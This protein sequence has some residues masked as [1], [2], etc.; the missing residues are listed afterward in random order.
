M[1]QRFLRNSVWIDPLE[2]IYRGDI[3]IQNGCVDRLEI[4]E[5]LNPHTVIA[6]LPEFWLPGFVDLHSDAIEKIVE[7]RPRVHFPLPFALRN[8]DRR[9]VTSGVTSCF[10]AI[11][12][13]GKER[14]LRSPQKA[15]AL[16]EALHA[17]RD[18]S[19][20]RNFIHARYEVSD[21][22]G[23]IHIKELIE[24]G[25][26]DLLSFMDHSPGQ[27]QFRREK[28]FIR[29]LMLTYT[30]TE[31]K[32]R[33]LLREKRQTYAGAN[34]RLID[35]AQLA[36]QH[37]IRFVCHD[38]DNP[39]EAGAWASLGASISEFP[40]TLDAAEASLAAGLATFLGAPNLVRGESSGN[41]IKASAAIQ[42]GFASGICSD[43]LP[44]SLLG[45]L[46]KALQLGG[47]PLTL[48][49]VVALFTRNPAK[50]A[51]QEMLGRVCDGAPADLIRLAWE[52]D[53]LRLKETLIAGETVFFEAD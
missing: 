29:Y 33:A 43:Y 30:K 10:H 4:R 48:P 15:T 39:A 40:M 22:V 12:F 50:A 14:G 8:M 6:S 7:P 45:G 18:Q 47:H 17:A 1:T 5:T 2:G 3:R 49:Q 16:I 21:P 37:Q 41:G 28:D 42:A 19:R 38:L 35:L 53:N 34:E 23:P 36:K 44:E 13:A 25:L 11:S 51:N 24:R 20:C 52:G 31:K 46:Q 26:I 32:C 9:L 27:G